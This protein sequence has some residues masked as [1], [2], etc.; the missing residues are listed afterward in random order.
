MNIPD[1]AVVEAEGATIGKEEEAEEESDIFETIMAI[2][3]AIVTCAGGIVAWRAAVASNGAGNANSDGLYAALNA[4]ETLTLTNSESY[5]H[6][7]A[8]TYYTEKDR[9]QALI[10]ADLKLTEA[11]DVKRQQAEAAG[12]AATSRLFFPA[13]YLNRDGS[14]ATER[15]LGEA[16]AQAEQTLD[17][18]PDPYFTAADQLSIKTSWLVGTFV[19]LSV[20]LLLYTLAEGLHPKRQVL[21]YAVALIATLCFLASAGA[22]VTVEVLLKG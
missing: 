8:Y 1:T 20:A 7:R 21:R 12:M 5:R 22:A 6:Y 11:P 19:F 18:N 14:Y 15:E 2:L 13:R 9:L 4:Q 10:E 17:L 3:I 16:W